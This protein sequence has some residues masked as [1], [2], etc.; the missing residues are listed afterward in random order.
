MKRIIIYPL[1][2]MATLF[3]CIPGWSQGVGDFTA[4]IAS[5]K[6]KYPKTDVIAA[7]YREEYQFNIKNA[8]NSV[9]MVGA[10][11]A[12]SSTLVPLKDFA[13]NSDAIFYDGE[14]D[15]EG[16]QAINSKGKNI[17]FR[18]QCM[19]YQ[20]DGIF[21]SDA[22]VCVVAV[23][24]EEKGKPASYS[25]NKKYK[26]VK[27]LTSVY[28]HEQVPIEEKTVVFNIP[29]WLE[30]DLREFN[31]KGYDIKKEVQK[32]AAAKLTRYSYRLK[33][34]PSLEK[35]FNAPNL[36]KS[37][38]HIIVVSKSY[39]GNGQKKVLFESVKDLYNWYYALRKEVKNQPDELKPLV[40]QLTTGKKSDIEKIESVYY[41]VQD[42]IRYIAFENGIMGFKPD[43][44]QNV[45]K[46]KY[47]DCKGKANLLTE[48]L[49]I[50]G[51]DARLTW[52]G[53]ADLP[54]DYSLPSLAV[55][56]H[57]ICTVILNGKKYY[58]D[59]TE[60]NIAFNDYA[61]RIQGKEVLIED[62]DKYILDKI[63]EFP[64]ERN[65]IETGMKL[66]T[67][68]DILSGTVTTTWHGESKTG[69]VA[70]YQLLRNENKKDLLENFLRSGN[71]NI[72]ISNI[73]DPNWND[74][75]QP[76]KVSFDVQ[77][78]HRITKAGNE[79]YIT[80][81]WDKDLANLE[82][83]ST[84]R[85]D[86]EL[87][88]KIWT[89][90]QVEFA[91]PDGYKVDYLPESLSVKKADYSFEGAFTNKGN[92]ILY[93]K[94]I[95]VNTPIIKKSDFAA[96]NEFIKSINKFYSDQIVLVKK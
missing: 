26:D 3:C 15:I 1:C 91:I 24:L 49:R 11:C 54:Y 69:L 9:S 88:H 47:G 19:D 62:G 81:D 58:L 60:A 79:L 67:D 82:F 86:Y 57:M 87:N 66:K 41:W 25:Y 22:R 5:F 77:A 12:V 32:D 92:L 13:T 30:V 20:S 55:D 6:V 84:R 29:D 56:N 28:F 72:S 83:D 40:N 80:L 46:N 18:L 38:P 33:H 44:A 64:A 39:T 68:G 23:P 70:S 50:A 17:P 14:S 2:L 65:K 76:L 27:Y 10:Q 51:Y 74:R 61:H 95:Q 90:S 89:S 52:I 7:H 71:A 34:I 94:K 31:F 93:N 42:K 4:D 16:V 37:Y 59:G 48:M 21:Y 36:A 78:R 75:Q 8:S 63:P 53:T 43:A 85:N 96:W 45:L 73:K 35:E